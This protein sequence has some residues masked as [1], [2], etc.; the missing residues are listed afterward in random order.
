MEEAIAAACH[1]PRFRYDPAAA[2]AAEDIASPKEAGGAKNA[3]P[4]GKRRELTR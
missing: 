3:P 4:A 1:R 2:A